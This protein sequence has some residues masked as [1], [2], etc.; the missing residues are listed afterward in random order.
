MPAGVYLDE[1]LGLAIE[2]QVRLRAAAAS[3]PG[4]RVERAAV[5]QRGANDPALLAYAAANDLVLVSR[6]V[7]DLLR[8]NEIWTILREWG[9]ARQRHAGIL[10]PLGAVRDIDWANRV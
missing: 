6:N 7:Q 9:L 1:M 3:L 4:F 10:V 2:Q 5:V 8:L